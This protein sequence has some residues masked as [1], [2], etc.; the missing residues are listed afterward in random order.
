MSRCHLSCGLFGAII[1]LALSGCGKGGSPKDATDWSYSPPDGFKQQDK[2]VKGATVFIGP[3]D[4]GFRS[5]LQV[6]SG[7]N[8]KETAKDVADL[9]LKKATATGNITVKEQ[10]AYTVP[11]SDAY[12]WLIEKRLANGKNA[13]QRQFVVMKNGVAVLFTMT[14]AESAMPKYDQALADSIQTFKWGK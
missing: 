8:P 7:T 4:D 9:A 1:I 5:N 14:A 3:T 2:Q 12:T 6:L 11:D 10:E 13:E